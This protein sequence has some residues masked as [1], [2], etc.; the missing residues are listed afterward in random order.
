MGKEDRTSKAVGGGHRTVGQGRY[1]LQRLLGEGGMASV[2]LAHDTVLDRPVAVKALHPDL[3][4]EP[5]FRERF[6]REAR[7]V[8]RLSH[9]NVVAVHDS[10]EDV[11]PDG[12]TALYIVMEYVEGATLSSLLREAAERPSSLSP[13]RAL[14]IIADVL[15]ALTASHEQG[16]IH[17][18]IKPA[19]IMVTS[20]NVVKVM[21]FGIARALQAGSTSLTQ[22]GM[23]IGTPQYISPEQ[24][25]GRD[26]DARSD[27]YSVGCLLFEMLTGRVPFDG[28]SALTIA[29]QH[30]QQPPPAPSGINRAVGPEVDALVD[31]A[32]QKAPAHRFPTAEVMR[33]A[34]EHTALQMRNGRNTLVI[35]TPRRSPAPVVPGASTTGTATAETAAAYGAPVGPTLI[36]D[37][38]ASYPPAAAEEPSSP[39][40][41]AWTDPGLTAPA[42]R[43]LPRGRRRRGRPRR[44]VVVA[45][46][47][48]VLTS[49]G[50]LLF[51]L[52]P[53]QETS[54][55][56]QAGH[57]ASGATAGSPDTGSRAEAA[58]HPSKGADRDHP[59]ADSSTTPG[60]PG[61]SGPPGS[62]P[63]SSASTAPASGTHPRP[64]HSG[65]TTHAPGEPPTSPSDPS[66][67]APAPPDPSQFPFVHSPASNGNFIQITWDNRSDE[68]LTFTIFQTTSSGSILRQVASLTEPADGTYSLTDAN[69]SNP[70]CYMVR[71]TTPAGGSFGNSNVACA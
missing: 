1:V 53:H 42:D 16:L 44:T 62:A 55:A 22:H 58:S 70:K 3:S 27:L 30:V 32:L 54:A 4:R 12:V 67:P 2:H 65:S 8:A 69:P 25:L 71:A 43:K 40:T 28:D 26:I 23:T 17:R 7:S 47:L 61:A 60:A 57:L 14:E 31:R 20:R 15:R 51:V 11:R 41:P 63:S 19:N 6:R 66:P 10:G 5:S 48:T 33:E 24:V 34:V 50:T 21:D 18:D 39:E 45:A 37:A 9:T 36:E 59:S 13:A 38:P 64:P 46:A 56:T 35:G 68:R 49:A 52:N 29:Y